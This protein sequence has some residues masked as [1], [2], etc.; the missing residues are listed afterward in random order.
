MEFIY[1]CIIYS[2]IGDSG[3]ERNDDDSSEE[4]TSKPVYLD[5]LP[6]VYQNKYKSLIEMIENYVLAVS[7]SGVQSEGGVQIPM[8][9]VGNNYDNIA[10][11]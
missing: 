5:L 3:S 9:N 8:K 10:A 11:E 6:V 7:I 4:E 1:L 2:F